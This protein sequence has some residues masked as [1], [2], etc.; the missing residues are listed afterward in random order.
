VL[1]CPGG[2]P[3]ATSEQVD[4]KVSTSLG[5]VHRPAQA[6]QSVNR[7][8]GFIALLR[9]GFG[10]PIVL[11]YSMT[12]SCT[13]L[14]V[15]CW[16]CVFLAFLLLLHKVAAPGF[17]LCSLVSR[18]CAYMLCLLHELLR[19]S[20]SWPVLRVVVYCCSLLL[21][22]AGLGVDLSLFGGGEVDYMGGMWCV[23]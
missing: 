12:S 6:Q 17:A 13:L 3:E 11:L 22:G 2:R 18:F 16:R 8:A 5:V 4:N 19:P 7:L 14:V 9:H 23:S 1:L 21:M 10:F 20:S 15:I